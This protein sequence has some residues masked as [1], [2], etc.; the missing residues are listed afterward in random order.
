MAL[1]IKA[2]AD[3]L[4]R[5]RKQFDLSMEEMAEETG[6]SLEK[7]EALENGKA[8]PSGDD[9]LILADYFKCDYNFFISNEKHTAFE[10]TELLFRR[11]GNEISK[12]DRWAIQE[13]IY[14]AEC[15]SFLD[16][17][18][19][20]RSHAKF[21]Y[22]P[23]GTYFKKHGE[24]AAAK[25]RDF[26]YEEANKLYLDIY[27]D[28]RRA[29]FIIYR[30]R[31]ESS[32]LSG[33]CI[34]YPGIGKILLVNYDDDIFRQRFTVAHEIGHAIFDNEEGD[35]ELSYNGKWDKSDLREIRANTF[36]ANFLVP[37]ELLS[38]IPDNK[39]WNGDKLIEWA[40]KAKIN[41]KSLVIALKNNGLISNMDA[42][43]L[44]RYK[45]PENLKIDPELV[46]MSPETTKRLTLLFERGL[47]YQYLN[48]CIKA[49]RENLISLT[50]MAEMLLL[51]QS[52]I[53]ELNKVF[54]LGIEYAN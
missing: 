44:E 15:E 18:Y 29:G 24:D 32:K 37:K 8:E 51:N 26:L 42:S 27:S 52:E 31:L 36:A 47:T 20:S 33:V 46:G 12:N 9:V 4:S 53:C 10:K 45:V 35:I 23:I 5:Y 14:L 11:Y 3:K 7:I 41:T 34:D 13:C 50:R 2:F 43:V 19:G 28:F 1:D 25:L 16:D 39:K 38:T 6:I 17:I 22:A 30:R 21:T 54:K 48:K 49:Q 40:L